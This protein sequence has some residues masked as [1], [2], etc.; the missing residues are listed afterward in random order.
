MAKFT[1]AE[2][3]MGRATPA[4]LDSKTRANMDLLLVR[5]NNFFKDL[6]PTALS[7]GYRTS[8]A[9][10]AAGGASRSWHLQAAAADLRDADGTV[11]QY[12]LANLP[13]AA[14]LGIWFEDKRWCKGWTHVQ[15]YPPASGKRIYQPK[16]GAP[17]HPE[18]WNGDYDRRLDSKL[19]R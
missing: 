7:S 2:Y 12:V 3:L 14:E 6:P 9:N 19:S 1:A 10:S 8:T 15:I 16:V 17:P 11:W 13:R 4:T 18:L 5:M